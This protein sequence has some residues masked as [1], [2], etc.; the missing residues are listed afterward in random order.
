MPVPARTQP[1]PKMATPTQASAAAEPLTT[2]AAAAVLGFSVETI[3]KY[4]AE[5]GGYRLGGNGPWRFPAEQIAF[6]RAHPKFI[7]QPKAAVREL[8]LTVEKINF[9]CSERERRMAHALAAFEKRL[10]GLEA[11]TGLAK[12]A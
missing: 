5:L 2:A 8:F 1:Q 4:R 10:A 9:L 6:Y 11:S 12:A 3:R 7:T